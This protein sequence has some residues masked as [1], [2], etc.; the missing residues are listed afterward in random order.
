MKKLILLLMVVCSNTVCANEY[1]LQTLAP[2][3]S[4]GK[5]GDITF[6]ASKTEFNATDNI[7]LTWNVGGSAS[8]VSISGVGVVSKEGTLTYKPGVVDSIVLTAKLGSQV[9]TQTINTS[10]LYDAVYLANSC[11]GSNAVSA[12]TNHGDRICDKIFAN[13]SAITGNAPT[14]VSGQMD[15]GNA[16]SKGAKIYALV[17]YFNAAYTVNGYGYD[18]SAKA[19]Y[20]DLYK[21]NGSTATLIQTWTNKLTNNFSDRLDLTTPVA[22]VNGDRFVI[23]LRQTMGGVHTHVVA[24]EVTMLLK[25]NL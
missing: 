15:I 4:E 18:G 24:N 11:R 6:L 1:I 13:A 25:K 16:T 10:A 2:G 8:E 17:H 9:A 5:I 21:L 12:T 3:V 23:R 14:G 22:V 20:I 19:K 7:T